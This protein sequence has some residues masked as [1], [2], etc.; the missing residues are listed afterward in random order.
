MHGWIIL[1]K[2][3]G[4][5][6]TQ[7][8]SAVKRA[9]RQGGYGKAKVGHGG[10]LDPLATGVLPIAVGEATKLAGRMLDSDKAYAFTIRFGEQTDTLDAEGS[11]VATSPVRPTMAQ[12]D[13]VLPRF[14]GPISQVPPAYS[15]LK[16]DGTRAYDLARAG[17]EVVL[18]SRDVTVHAL[19]VAADGAGEVTL[20]AHVSKGTYIRSLAR[21]IALALG[22]VGHVTMLRR[23]KAGPFDLAHAISLDKLSQAGMAREL[24]QIL[25][26]LRAGL[27]DIPALS[28]S[29]DQA[30][31][32]RQ[33]R[34]LIGIAADDGPYFACEGDTPVALVSVEGH[35]ARV[36]RGFNL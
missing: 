2:P 29:P 31:A 17:E 7:A 22:S 11:V 6:S 3:L 28:L 18:K 16:V 8:V 35:E 33:G 34:V 14:T 23:L 10:T 1:D 27:D 5:G 25:L 19:H 15:A 20:E 26:P 24:E 12:I 32:L 13:G 9:L 30:G 21:D 4:L 36:V